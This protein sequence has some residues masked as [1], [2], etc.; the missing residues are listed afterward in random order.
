MR[1]GVSDGAAWLNA[2]RVG[3]S[4]RSGQD[5]NGWARRVVAARAEWVRHV[6]GVGGEVL[7]TWLVGMAGALRVGMTRHGGWAWNVRRVVRR[8][9]R[10]GLS[11]TV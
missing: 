1:V 11:V 4:V 2:A 6:G 7:A 10:D 5:V 3:L 9:C 8:R